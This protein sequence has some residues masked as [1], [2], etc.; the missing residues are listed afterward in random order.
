MCVVGCLGVGECLARFARGGEGRRHA[1]TRQ[2]RQG[3][4]AKCVDK[5]EDAKVG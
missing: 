5:G 2:A 3:V 4:R 1:H